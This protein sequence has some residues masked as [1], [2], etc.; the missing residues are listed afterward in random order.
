MSAEPTADEKFTQYGL[1]L[2][3]VVD[4]AI[5]P[6]LRSLYV[7]RTST[8]PC[9]ATEAA[10]ESVAQEAN[11]LLLELIESDI[12]QPL[13]GPLERIRQ[14][15]GPLNAELV[16]AGAVPPRRDPIDREM[17]PEDIFAIGPMVFADLGDEVHAAGIQWG[18]AKAFIHLE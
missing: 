3:R 1:E 7:D 4:A 15:V 12:D 6:W 5:R 8:Q 9:A 18:A 14:A 2:V 16:S 17:R 11:R 10:I 13:S